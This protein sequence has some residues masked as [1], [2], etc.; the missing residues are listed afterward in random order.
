MLS[1]NNKK[2]SCDSPK[3]ISS[4]TFSFQI[5]LKIGFF[6]SV[7]YSSLYPFMLNTIVFYLNL[8]FF[9]KA[10]FVWMRILFECEFWWECEFYWNVT[11]IGMWLLLECEFYWN[12]NSIGMRILLECEFYLNTNSIKIRILLECNFWSKKYGNFVV[13]NQ[14]KFELRQFEFLR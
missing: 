11:S 1:H 9:L 12:V 6:D 7:S 14:T 8:D 2:Q 13:P 4:S 5:L 10:N 3:Y